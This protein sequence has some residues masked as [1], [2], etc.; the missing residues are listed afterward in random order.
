M[1]PMPTSFY[2]YIIESIKTGKWYYGATTNLDQRLEHHNKGWNRSTRGRGPW[3]FALIKGFNSW[4]EARKFEV[5]LKATRNKARIRRKFPE[6]F[7]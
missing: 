3:R 7:L 6:L 1:L 5:E 2:A 4:K